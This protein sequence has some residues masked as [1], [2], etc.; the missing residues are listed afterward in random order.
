MICFKLN[1]SVLV[2]FTEKKS[3][4]DEITFCL[5]LPSLVVLFL[6]FII[7]SVSVVLVLTVET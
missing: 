1:N 3:F 6:I 4:I 2:V 5:R 7:I